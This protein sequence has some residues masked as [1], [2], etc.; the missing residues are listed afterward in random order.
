MG[1]FHPVSIQKGFSF[2]L[3]LL[4]CLRDRISKIVKLGM[5]AGVICAM[6]IMSNR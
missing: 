4:S 5:Q 3:S 1:I 2:N 6:Q